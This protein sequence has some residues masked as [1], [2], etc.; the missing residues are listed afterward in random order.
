MPFLIAF[1][2]GAAVGSFLNVCIFRLPAGQS[3]VTPA[4]RCPK[5]R[6]AIAW[7]DNIPC[8]S[9]FALGGKCRHCGAAI[10]AQ[11]AA[12][13]FLTGFLFVLFYLVFGLSAK[14]VA[15]LALTLGL[16]V[17]SFID[18][19]YK[20]IP[21]EITLPGMVAAVAAS[22]LWPGLHGETVWVWGVLRSLMGLAAGGGILWAAGSIAGRILKKEAM[23]GGDVKLLAMIGA[24]LG[25]QAV[26]WIVFIS[27]FLGSAAGIYLRLKKGEAEIP[28]GP[29]LAAAA[30]FYIFFG[31]ALVQGYLNFFAR[32]A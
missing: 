2:S 1:L 29:Y 13:E 28:Y 14:G 15:Y 8:V 21:D 25:W 26:L 31:K 19:R 27:S 20:I 22:A 12:V 30:V 32:G 3:V 4:S 7:H 9:F 11:Y 23:G 24:L 6:H 16:V 5:C 17:E 10:S 18:F